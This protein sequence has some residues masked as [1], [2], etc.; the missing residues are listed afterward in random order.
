[1][2][3]KKKATNPYSTEAWTIN[4]RALLLEKWEA[5]NWFIKIVAN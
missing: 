5:I 2:Q 3:G 4:R 1:M